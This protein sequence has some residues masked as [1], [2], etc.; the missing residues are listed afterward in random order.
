LE[1]G[2]PEDLGKSA[3]GASKTAQ[4]III[5]HLPMSPFRRIKQLLFGVEHYPG[6]HSFIN[7]LFQNPHER[8][9]THLLEGLAVSA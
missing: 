6:A 2:R 9:E 7:Q 8:E 1:T 5:P 4:G 3:R